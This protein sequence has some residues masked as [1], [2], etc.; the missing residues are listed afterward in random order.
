MKIQLTL[1]LSILLFFPTF[2]QVEQKVIIEHFTNTRCGTCANKNP[3]FYETLANYPQVLHVAYHPSSPYANCAFNQQNKEDNDARTHFYNIYGG[4]PRAVVQSDVIPPQNP[5]LKED[6]IEARL[7]KKSDYAVTVTNKLM[8][9]NNYIVT[10]DIEQVSGNENE[11][12]DLYLALA[13]K[14]VNYNAPN[15]EDVHHDVFRD[16]LY[17]DNANVSPSRSTTLIEKEYIMKGEWD[18]NEIYAYAIIHNS[19]TKTILQSGSSLDAPTFIGDRKIEEIRNLFYPNPVTNILNI[20]SDY[21]QQIQKV[22]L[23]SLVGSKVKEFSTF[24]NMDISELPDGLYFAKLTDFQNR[25][26][27]T[28][29]IKRR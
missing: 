20:N 22:E 8:S 16:E 3:A 13:E 19:T 4:T 9:G 27:S 1:A 29:L 15:G 2:A 26:F 18:A 11:S 6:Q 24:S 25:Q 21:S 5:L 14:T 7:G 23:Y 10:V 28:R 17:F 12:I